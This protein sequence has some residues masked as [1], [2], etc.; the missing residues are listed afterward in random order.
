AVN[1]VQLGGAVSPA[2]TAPVATLRV[3]TPVL[4]MLAS[5]TISSASAWP[6]LMMISA[7]GTPFQLLLMGKSNTTRPCTPGSPLAE[8]RMAPS[9]FCSCWPVGTWPRDPRMLAVLEVFRLESA[10]SAQVSANSG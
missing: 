10:N 3:G 6:P 4:G 8:P 1:V 7:L 9:R 2:T 5:G